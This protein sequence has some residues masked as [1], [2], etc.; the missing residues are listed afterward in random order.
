MSK[1]VAL[2][3]FCSGARAAWRR[4]WDAAEP[5]VTEVLGVVQGSV[6]SK[7]FDE[8]SLD[9]PASCLEDRDQFLQQGG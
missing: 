5:R 9:F 2:A 1:K 6:A 3:C 7:P 4:L 8:S